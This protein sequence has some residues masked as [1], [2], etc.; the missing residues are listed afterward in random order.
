MGLTVTA[1]GV[2]TEAVLQRLAELGCDLAQGYFICRPL[3]VAELETW[4]QTSPWARA[5][6]HQRALVDKTDPD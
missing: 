3:G 2:E 1:E 6:H 5:G 4:L